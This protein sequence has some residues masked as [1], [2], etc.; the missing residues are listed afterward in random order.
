MRATI[1]LILVLILCHSFAHSD[2]FI[3]KSGKKIEGTTRYENGETIRIVESSGLEMT[4][5]KSELNLA[6]TLAANIQTAPTA[7]ADAAPLGVQESSPPKSVIKI[8][9]NRDLRLQKV[10]FT[11]PEF[12][13]DPSWKKSLAK[14]EREFLRLQAACRNAGTGRNISKVLRS[15]TYSVNG[16]KLKVTGYFADPA[17]IEEAKQICARAIQTQETLQQARRDFQDYQNRQKDQNT[18][19]VGAG[20]APAR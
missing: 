9:T 11:P 20:L 3:F 8:Y 14:L 10:S 5:R 15:E 16:K 1:F 18:P 17:N 6:A 13:T 2:V 19:S 7:P 4:L 12:E